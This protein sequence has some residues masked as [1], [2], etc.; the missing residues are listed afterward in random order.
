MSDS[1][2][3]RSFFVPLHHRLI[4]KNTYMEIYIVK[5]GDTL[6]SI[7]SSFGISSARLSFD[8][9]V[10]G[11]NVVEGE[12][13]LISI[14]QTTYVITEGDT[15]SSIAQAFQTTEK[16]LLRHNPYL[17]FTEN[18][19]VGET[20]I[21]SYEG[22]ASITDSIA[23]NGYAYPFIAKQ[24]LYETL[25]Y[26][27]SLYIFSY[28]FTDEGNLIPTNDEE[29]LAAAKA[30]EVAP[31][32]VLTGLDQ[33]GFFSNELVHN[34]LINDAAQTQLISEL[35]STMTAKGYTGVDV[36]FEFIYAEDRERYVNFI[37]RLTN[38]LNPNGFLVTVALPPKTSDEQRGLLYEGI[39]YAGLGAAA[40]YVLLMTYEWG[41][42][43]GPPMAVAPIPSVRRVLDYAVTRIDPA[44]INMGIPNYGYDWPLPYIR[45]E[46]K[47][48]S[49]GNA[50]AVRIAWENGANIQYD[51]V[52]KAPFFYYSDLDSPEAVTEHVVWFEDVRSFNEKYNLVTEYGFNGVGY[53]QLMRFFRA[54]WLLVLQTF[55][56]L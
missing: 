42:T 22:E 28:G 14:P 20:I 35:I 34:L 19:Q 5:P 9:Q 33:Y 6:I 56:I 37:S 12:A 32:L 18:L 40:N 30:F 50:Q 25:L 55:R 24:T 11:R 39:D 7:A 54:N 4:K 44:K 26:L 3:N 21:I 27:T 46:T 41:Y 49:I 53:W 43:F 15:L 1:F 31:I 17:L 29:L 45:G 47:A 52:S 38:E 8:N 23:V 48:T 51:D 13:L 10:A 2:W 16:N 36:D